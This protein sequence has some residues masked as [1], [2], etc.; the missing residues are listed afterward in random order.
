MSVTIT[1]T[2]NPALFGLGIFEGHKKRTG[3]ACTINTV[4]GNDTTSTLYR[5]R[6]NSLK[7]AMIH[8]IVPAT[9]QPS[10]RILDTHHTHTYHKDEKQKSKKKKKK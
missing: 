4:T 3:N 5:P 9:Q 10:R 2:L 1:K 6:S 8:Y 7:D